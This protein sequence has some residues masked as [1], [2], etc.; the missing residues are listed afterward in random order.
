MRGNVVK[1][2]PDFREKAKYNILI[3]SN[4]MTSIFIIISLLIFGPT[5]RA[6]P[7]SHL[8][9]LTQVGV[10]AFLGLPKIAEKSS[11]G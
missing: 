2:Y 9:T 3:S 10:S 8:G 1:Y 11:K 4:I 5:V 7:G 6:R